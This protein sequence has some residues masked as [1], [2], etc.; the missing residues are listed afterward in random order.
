MSIA[1]TPRR[2]DRSTRTIAILIALGLTTAGACSKKQEPAANTA[3]P[4]FDASQTGGANAPTTTAPPGTHAVYAPQKPCKVEGLPKI[5]PTDPSRTQNYDCGTLTVPE[6]RNK[7]LGKKIKLQVVVLKSA[8]P[9]PKPDPI[10]YLEG[11]PG[12]SALA[13]VEGWVREFK[14]LLAERDVILMDQRGTGYSEPTVSCTYEEQ[15]AGSTETQVETLTKCHDRLKEDE[16]NFA[17]Y[18][19]RSNAAD[20]ADL[21]AALKLT[22]WNLFGVSYGTRL[23]LQM[24]NDSPTGIRSVIIDSNFPAGVE[25]IKEIPANAVRSFKAVFDACG[26]DAACA[27]ANPDL[28]GSL[29]TAIEKLDKYPVRDNNP[30]KAREAKHRQFDGSAFAHLLFQLLYSSRAIQILPQ[31]ITAASKDPVQAINEYF[32]GGGSGDD[33]RPTFA[34]GFYFTVTCAE[35]GPVSDQAAMEAI[36]PPIDV[37]IR[38]AF[39]IDQLESYEICKRWN[40]P[41]S[42]VN[43]P[44]VDIPSL[45]FAGSFDPITPPSWSQKAKAAL[46]KSR[47][48]EIEGAGHGAYF[49]GPCAEGIAVSFLNDPGNLGGEGGCPP[50]TKFMNRPLGR[51]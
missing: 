18:N 41:P 29:A 50:V 1:T 17:A 39:V 47:Y 37:R 9:T 6:D 31:L 20:F 4:N 21:R 49:T 5:D 2:R 48:V 13:R 23:A 19:T 27:A 28:E 16:F 30:F 45:V 44:T 40:I 25:F 10:V 26:A 36:V 15:R 3:T 12:G 24:M 11:G 8:N 22:E 32:P 51:F 14:P 42:E 46:P 34:D 7:P 33:G 35:L 43:L 38:N